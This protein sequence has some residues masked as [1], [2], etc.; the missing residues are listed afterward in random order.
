MKKILMAFVLIFSVN[1]VMAQES[2]EWKGWYNTLLKGLKTKVQSRLESKTRVSAVAAVRGAK[3]G[4]DPMSLYWKG[5]VSDNAQKK[6]DT[7][8]A[9]FTSAVQLA[10]DGSVEEGRQALSKFIRDNQDSVFV[11]DAKDALSKLPA[12]EKVEVKTPSDSAGKSETQA[13]SEEMKSETKSE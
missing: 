6:L 4:S 10:V 1:S 12:E 7:E 3:Q 11:Q 2:K 13:I 8:K 5:G 9:Q